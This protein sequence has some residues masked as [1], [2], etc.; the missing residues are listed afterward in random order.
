MLYPTPLLVTHTAAD[1][2]QGI[3]DHKWVSIHIL[4]L[5]NKNVDMG[6]KVNS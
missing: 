6:L 5:S 1:I 4:L 3:L 2:D